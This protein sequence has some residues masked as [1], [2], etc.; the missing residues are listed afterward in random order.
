LVVIIAVAGVE[1]DRMFEV[2]NHSLRICRSVRA[3]GHSVWLAMP[4]FASERPKAQ[5]W[6]TLRVGIVILVC[7]RQARY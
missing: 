3:S 2:R 6:R 7:R 1:S 5:A 4:T